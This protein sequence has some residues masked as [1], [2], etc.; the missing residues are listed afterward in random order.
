M[1]AI[2]RPDNDRL[3]SLHMP[4]VLAPHT[5]RDAIPSAV[6]LTRA[7]ASILHA[8]FLAL[9][10]GSVVLSGV[11]AALTFPALK[12]L[13]PVLPGFLTPPEDHWR[14]AAGHV[15][16]RVFAVSG[17]VQLACLAAAGAALAIAARRAF[18]ENLIHW[19]IL[20]LL[21]LVIGYNGA[22]LMPRMTDNLQRYWHASQS[23]DLSL[24]ASSQQAFDADHPRSTR[25]L[26]SL[27]LLVALGVILAAWR[28]VQG[29]HPLSDA[30]PQPPHTPPEG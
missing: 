26:V 23:G 28:P 8:S 27:S 12:R 22:I 4:Q 29:A 2:F 1:T 3:T 14:I 7:G 30:P 17:W 24:A 21:A 16:F 10:L 5:R 13:A 6:A 18:R 20:S 19:F 11:V 25:L 15:A 9:C